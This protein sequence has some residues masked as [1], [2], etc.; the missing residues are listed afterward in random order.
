MRSFINCG[1]KDVGPEGMLGKCQKCTEDCEAKLYD[2]MAARAIDNPFGLFPRWIQEFDVY[3]RVWACIFSDIDKL[4]DRLSLAIKI[5]TIFNESKDVP[6]TTELAAVF[7]LAQYKMLA[8]IYTNKD[9]Y[10]PE[11]LAPI[12]DLLKSI[13]KPEVLLKR[14]DD[15]TGIPA[16]LTIHYPAQCKLTAEEKKPKE[17]KEIS[18]APDNMYG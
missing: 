12:N 1:N 18:K 3:T 13:T 10:T 6:I 11:Q 8:G 16:S 2:Y 14:H 7:T 15:I 5:G 17:K 4:E 9:K